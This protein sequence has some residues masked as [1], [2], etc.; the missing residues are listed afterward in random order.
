[1]QELDRKQQQ[2]REVSQQVA[3]TGDKVKELQKELRAL[4][5]T[6]TVEQIE[7]Q[8]AALQAQAAEQSTKLAGLK[9][10]GRL[11]SAADRAA[12]EKALQANL[13][14][15]SKR[16][17]IFRALWDSIR[18][19]IDANHKEMLEDMGIETDESVGEELSS[20]QRLF[21]KR[22]RLV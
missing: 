8:T 22:A 19:N 14:H 9:Q 20:Y 1:M 11:V 3:S 5:N 17:G 7:E 21:P 13:R 2:V 16:R 15:W 18:E 4:E 6:L 12:A 10:G